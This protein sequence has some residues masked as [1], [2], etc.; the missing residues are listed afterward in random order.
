M[1]EHPLTPEER[2]PLPAQ[3]EALWERDLTDPEIARELGCPVSQVRRIRIQAGLPSNY[4]HPLTEGT[5]G[6]RRR[7]YDKG[8]ND[9]EIARIQGVTPESVWFWR[10]R[11]GLPSHCPRNRK[12]SWEN[13]KE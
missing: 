4:V 5:P 8:L 10:R 7:L 6:E 11:L 3:V 12:T 2:K 1:Q 9:S 13:R